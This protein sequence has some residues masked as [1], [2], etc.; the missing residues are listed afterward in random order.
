MASQRRS[1]LINTRGPR[2]GKCN[3]CGESGRL[4]EDHTPPKS[5]RGVTGAEMHALHL[6]VAGAPPLR[7]RH[8]RNGPSYRTLCAHCNNGLLGAVYDPALAYFCAEVRRATNTRIALPDEIFVD[9]QPQL[10]MRSV[11]GHLAAMGVGRYKK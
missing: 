8:F 4:T 10:V 1:R 11:L 6:M 2:E 9:I 3:I 5:C 7:G